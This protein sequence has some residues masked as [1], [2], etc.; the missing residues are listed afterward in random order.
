[1]RILPEYKKIR[2]DASN[3]EIPAFDLIVVLVLE[4]LHF[5]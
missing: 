3:G 4:Q 2:G 5:F 1:M